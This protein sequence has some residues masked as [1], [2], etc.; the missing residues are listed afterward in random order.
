MSAFERR[1]KLQGQKDELA[2]PYLGRRG[3]AM[4]TVM[5]AM[6]IGLSIWAISYRQL[7]SQMA[8]EQ[9]VVQGTGDG[10][11]PDIGAAFAYYIR[12]FRNTPDADQI[13]PN[14]ICK[15]SLGSGG[16]L[17]SY[18]VK[19]TDGGG[20][21]QYNIKLEV[22]DPVANPSPVACPCGGSN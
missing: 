6:V 4:A 1:E 22:W 3:L 8:F 14:T 11:R 13:A 10:V 12:C 9:R 2:R 17:A 20:A 15:F 21:G 5:V 19:Y 18:Q 16:T 7:S